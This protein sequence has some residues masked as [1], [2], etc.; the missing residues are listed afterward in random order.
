MYRD[1]L[2]DIDNYATEP[3][4]FL[5]VPFVPSDEEVID[6]MLKLGR[7]GP[8]DLVYDLGSGDGRILIAAARDRSA[9]GI[10]IE[11]DPQ[12]I[13]DA[14]E[15]AGWA[16]VECEVD[17]IEEDIFEAD[18]SPATVVTLYLLESVNLELR[19]QLLRQLRPGTRIVSH[20][21]DM[22]DWR[23]DDK[24]NLGGVNIYKWIVPAQV[25]GDW[26]WTCHEG[27]SYRL[28]LRQKFQDVSGKVWLDGDKAH[29]DDLAL[30][31][32]QLDIE[33]RGAKDTASHG[34]ALVFDKGMLTSV[35]AHEG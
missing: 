20:A 23:P 8:K 5:D 35:T 33:I 21:F 27:R 29:L 10:G 31:G 2:D 7:V 19:P 6:A 32:S 34:F 25:A 1:L 24:L 11:L 14:M 30:N 18:C 13:A 22:G 16:G 4:R 12:R 26:E 9:R 15:E 28:E 3:D 17:F